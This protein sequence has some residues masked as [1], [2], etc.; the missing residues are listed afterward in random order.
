MQ[1]AGK[2][3]LGGVLPGFGQARYEG[4]DPRAGHLLDELL[5]DDT[6]DP[7]R[8]RVVGD[9]LE[10]VAGRGGESPNVEF[11][12]GALCHV[13]GLVHG[14]GEVLFH[15]GR[16]AGW[17]AHALE[18]RDGRAQGVSADLPGRV[19]RGDRD[20]QHRRCATDAGD[21]RSGT[22]RPDPADA[23]SEQGY[24]D[25]GRRVGSRPSQRQAGA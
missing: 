10:L 7:V 16:S 25:R 1:S 22:A 9:V 3:A 20:G 6:A 2:L 12:L 13:H 18:E 23:R 19:R 24:R 8:R 15:L 4:V 14:A 11:A 21:R 5:A 17:L